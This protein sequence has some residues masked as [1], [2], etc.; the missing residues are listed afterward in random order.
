MF[1]GKST[2]YDIVE[3]VEIPGHRIGGLLECNL[4]Q[5][6]SQQPV[7]YEPHPLFSAFIKTYLDK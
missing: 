7:E 1:S 4:I 3:I 6:S 2:K 5:S